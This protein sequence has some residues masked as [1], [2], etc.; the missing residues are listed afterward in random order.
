MGKIYGLFFEFKVSKYFAELVVDVVTIIFIDFIFSSFFII[1][2]IL[3][4]SQHFII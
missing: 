4:N 1:G 2:I 3:I